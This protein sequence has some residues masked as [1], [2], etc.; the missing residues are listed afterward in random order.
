MYIVHTPKSVCG[1]VC[2]CWERG[3][4]LKLCFLPGCW[5]A[6]FTLSSSRFSMYNFVPDPAQVYQSP[7]IKKIGFTAGSLW[8]CG[9]EDKA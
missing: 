8:F 4:G 5:K 2:V 1:V 6:C 3:V 7:P 9:R